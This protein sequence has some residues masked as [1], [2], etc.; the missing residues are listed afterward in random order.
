MVEKR[1]SKKKYLP[2][3]ED[4]GSQQ[5]TPKRRDLQKRLFTSGGQPLNGVWVF[6]SHRKIA[7]TCAPT[8]DPVLA[9]GD[10]SVIQ[11][12]TQQ[13]PYIFLFGYKSTTT[14][15]TRAL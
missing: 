13:F 11:A 3:S 15:Q 4:L 1:Q 8:A 9:S 6:R 2:V 7:F 12:V 5:K 10:Q 14:A